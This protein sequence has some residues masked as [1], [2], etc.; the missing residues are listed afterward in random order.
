MAA[1]EDIAELDELDI[2]EHPNGTDYQLTDRYAREALD[3]VYTKAQINAMLSGKLDRQIV[4]TLPT[5]DI[6]TSTIYM[7]PKPSAKTN[8]TYDEYMYI[9]GNWELM[10]D[11]E[12][13]MSNYYTK[14]QIDSLLAAIIDDNIV[15]T[16]KT[17]SS[18]KLDESF[19][20]QDQINELLQSQV[21]KTQ[22]VIGLG[23]NNLIPYPYKET[24]K[25]HNGIT[26]TDNGDGSITVNGTATGEATFLLCGNNIFPTSDEFATHPHINYSLTGCPQGGDY[27]TGYSLVI[28]RKDMASTSWGGMWETG[29]GYN[30]NNDYQSSYNDVYTS[31]FI[32]VASGCTCNNV[33]FN[34][35]LVNVDDVSNINFQATLTP[36]NGIDINSNNVISAKVDGVTTQFDSNGNIKAIIPSLDDYYTKTQVD[37]GLNSKQDTLTAGTGIN[38]SNNVISATGGGGSSKSLIAS[39]QGT[40]A[41][42]SKYGKDLTKLFPYLVD[43][44]EDKLKDSFIVFKVATS[45]SWGLDYGVYRFCSADFVNK[46]AF[47]FML[48]GF[49]DNGTTKLMEMHRML[50]QETSSKL[51][52]RSMGASTGIQETDKSNYPTSNIFTFELYA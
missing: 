26:F 12:T 42:D 48:M 35:S 41:S 28:Q 33:V 20:T 34:P 44:P 5:T 45:G 52:T 43:L 2:L 21:T 14:A 30:F 3:N 6:S 36:G 10:G 8:N 29:D 49:R 22:E 15:S 46:S 16:T 11:T 25:T 51:V 27:Y 32:R 13:D 37:N 40:G 38:I 1:Y 50:I 7:V 19:I 47:V 31:I 18:S 4:Q 24:T 39:I 17:W 9:S 23:G